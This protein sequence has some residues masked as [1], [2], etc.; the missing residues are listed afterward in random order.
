ML[1]IFLTFL[2]TAEEK[3]QKKRRQGRVTPL[4][5]SADARRLSAAIACY[6]PPHPSLRPHGGAPRG[7]SRVVRVLGYWSYRFV[8]CA[9]ELELRFSSYEIIFSLKKIFLFHSPSGLWV[10]GFRISCATVTKLGFRNRFLMNLKAF[11]RRGGALA[12]ADTPHAIAADRRRASP[13][14]WVL[15]ENRRF[16]P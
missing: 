2:P 16:Y 1:F 11:R 3:L 8:L 13:G 12:L 14:S 4:E 7:S 9:A 5:P 6:E 10:H 15:R